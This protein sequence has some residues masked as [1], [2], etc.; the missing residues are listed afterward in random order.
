MVDTDFEVAIGDRLTAHMALAEKKD[1]LWE[2][3][4]KVIEAQQIDCSEH[5]YQSD[6]VIDNAFVFLDVICDIVGFYQYPEDA[7]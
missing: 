3:C 4:K 6:R 1:Q 7:N 2:H 5:I